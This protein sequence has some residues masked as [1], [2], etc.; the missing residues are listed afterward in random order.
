MKTDSQL[1]QDVMAELK[2]EPA[3]H[4]AQIGVEVK[5]GVVTLAGQVDSCAQKWHAEQAALRVAGVRTLTIKLGVQLPASDERT[6]ADIATAVRH[7]LDWTAVLPADAVKVQVEAG[8]VTLSG[9][10]EWM[11][12]RRAAND[13]VRWLTGVKGVHDEISLVPM[14]SASSVKGDI[15]AALQRSAAAD[16]RKIVVT[17]DGAD[18]TLSGSVRNTAERECATHA[19]WGTP[20]VRHV[21]D[22]LQMA[23]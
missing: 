8:W 21:V 5:D 23:W 1:Q 7:V 17:V 18:V 19:A 20:G 3:V 2:W 6:D 22:H 14:L 16:A 13:G 4:A 9:S 15:E 10:V 12:Q 11:F